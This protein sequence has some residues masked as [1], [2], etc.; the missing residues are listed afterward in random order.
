[1]STTTIS[2]SIVR[3]SNSNGEIACSLGRRYLIKI[4]RVWIS[5]EYMSDSNGRFIHDLYHDDPTRTKINKSSLEYQF[6]T[7]SKGCQTFIPIITIK[8]CVTL[9]DK[10]LFY[11][12]EIVQY[13]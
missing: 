3:C 8:P 11:E 12:S 7:L 10:C 5:L 6:D 2:S 13:S 1:M 9:C 4:T